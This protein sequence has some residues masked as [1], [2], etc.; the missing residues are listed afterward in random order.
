MSNDKER[1]SMLLIM[2][3]HTHTRTCIHVCTAL[4]LQVMVV[5]DGRMQPITIAGDRLSD[6]ESLVRK[7]RELPLP[8]PVRETH[9]ALTKKVFGWVRE[10]R[11]GWVSV[12]GGWVSE[13]STPPPP[14]P[15]A[16]QS[17]VRTTSLPSNLCTC[18]LEESG[19]TALGPALLVSVVMASKVPGSKVRR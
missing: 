1:Y 18:S 4:L 11:S 5:G 14:L 2:Y 8:A 16:P 12:V 17:L 9:K 15:P 10:W 6:S 3:T 7:A 13:C 19:Q